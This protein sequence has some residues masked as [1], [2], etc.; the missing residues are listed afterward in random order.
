MNVPVNHKR[1]KTFKNP[2]KN[3]LTIKKAPTSNY[4]N[5][6]YKRSSTSK[7]DI[8]KA[9]Y[10]AE[11]LLDE[12]DDSTILKN[13]SMFEPI[14]VNI[15]KFYYHLLEGIDWLYLVLGILG[16]LVC[17]LGGPVLSYLNATVYSNVGNTS[18]YRSDLTS[19][20]IMKLNVKET[21][22]SNVKKQMIYGSAS[23]V[24]NI[25][26]YHFLGLLSSRCLYTFKKRYFTVIL[27]QEQGWFDT[28][29]VFEFATKIQAQ[30][31]YIELGLGEG[32]A[33]VL[34]DIFIGIAS[35]IFAFF[36]SW[37]LSLVLLCF[38]PLSI[39]V[40][41]FLNNLNVKGN[42]LVRQTWEMA[43]GIGEEIFYNIKTVASFANFNYELNR[44]YEK[45][46]IS[47][48]IENTVNLKIRILSACFV[49]IGG[50]IVFVAVMYGRTLVVKD[51]NAL[52]GR[53][54]TGGDVTLTFCNMVSFMNCIGYVANNL[55]YIQ[56]SLAATSDYFNLY[57]R[58]P[59]MDLANSTEKP[60]FSDIKG[61][62]EFNNVN[63]YYPSDYN[64][65]LILNRMNL[66]F[67]AGKKIAL[68]GQ[69]GCGKTLW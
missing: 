36:G 29:N 50:I 22:E 12:T 63:F 7:F 66:N 10:E 58:K 62:I 43:G 53:D 19:E 30:L 56:L 3:A 14:N 47:N 57:E 67:K 6:I 35:L 65:K 46:E 59:E 9:H 21:M 40:G 8:E 15:F 26:G 49:F 20:E 18:E 61:Q 33:R 31:E 39:I 55:Q 34:V 5:Q 54:L 4:N 16:I 69:S 41:I 23:L 64:Q 2:L 51:F 37:K 44:F 68:I 25:V 28:T 48:K 17:A 11:L 24:G 52:R 1:T 42:T 32:L 38:T 45:V 27:S 60:P 13:Q